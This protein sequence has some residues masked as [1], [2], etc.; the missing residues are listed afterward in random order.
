MADM[1]RLAAYIGPEIS[2]G[3]FLLQP[4]H[5]LIQ[6]SW[7]PREMQG[8]RLNA[9]GYG[10]GWFAADN[11]PARFTHVMPIWADINLEALGRSLH[12]DV[13]VANVR[14]ATPGSPT[15][16][17]NTQP[18]VD[19]EFLFLHNGRID[20][21]GRKVRPRLR[22]L[23]TP[24]IEATVQGN[25][26]SE[27]LFALFRH[28]LAQDSDMAVEDAFAA[29]LEAVHALAAGSAVLLNLL[30]TDG[31]RLYALRH[32]LRTECPSLYFTTDDDDYPDG[33]LV[34]SEPLTPSRFW[35]AVPPQHLLILDPD[36][37]PR[38]ISL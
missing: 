32:A 23:L 4:A 21:F 36:E 25:T 6:Q 28:I 16:Q 15:N 34:A 2:L 26:D 33:L 10:F 31:E 20:D 24:E 11:L 7:Q 18:F 3:Q 35:Q 5:S 19:D 29:L 9:D 14:S 12:S 22:A 17:A 27:Y 38:L 30:L 1:C 37:P 13:W 8:A